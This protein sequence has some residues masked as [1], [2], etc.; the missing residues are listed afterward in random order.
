MDARNIA[1]LL[2]GGLLPP[3]SVSPAARRATRA[4]RW[5][6]VPLPRTRAALLT[7][8]QP[9]HR[10]DTLPELGK[11]SASKANRASV[12]ERFPAPAVPNSVAVDLALIAC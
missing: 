7:H 11:Q 10:Q 12:A 6:R 8:L 4:L 3:A 9:T 5:R 1:V 2:R